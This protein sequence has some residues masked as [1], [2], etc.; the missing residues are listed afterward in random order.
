MSG[1]L[2]GPVVTDVICHQENAL[3]SKWLGI[4]CTFMFNF[5]CAALNLPRHNFVDR[6]TEMRTRGY[7]WGVKEAGA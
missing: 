2:L 1:H 7:F 4:G 6:L 5:M 3:E